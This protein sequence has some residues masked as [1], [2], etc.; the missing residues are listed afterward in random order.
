MVKRESRA[1]HQRERPRQE[2]ELEGAAGTKS[3]EKDERRHSEKSLGDRQINERLSRIERFITM[4]LLKDSSAP[5]A[6]ERLL[7]R[8]RELSRVATEER[9]ILIFYR[10]RDQR[11]HG[12]I[13]RHDLGEERTA[14]KRRSE[15]NEERGAPEVSLAISADEEAWRDEEGAQCSQDRRQHHEPIGDDRAVNMR[16]AIERRPLEPEELERAQELERMDKR[17]PND[18][19]KERCAKKRKQ[20]AGRIAL[21]GV[22]FPYSAENSSIRR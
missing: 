10:G 11:K 22:L 15:G 1:T 14:D 9:E 2:E 20:S 4:V 8:K 19:P 13:E 17:E 16:D 12:P 6:Q 18:E 21:L 7:D 5:D 3:R